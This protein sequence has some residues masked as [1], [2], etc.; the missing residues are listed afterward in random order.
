MTT[1]DTE[2]T[3]F[4]RFQKQKGLL[5]KLSSLSKAGFAQVTEQMSFLSIGFASATTQ[6]FSVQERLSPQDGRLGIKQLQEDYHRIDQETKAVL[7]GIETLVGQQFTIQERLQQMTVWAMDLEQDTLLP[8]MADQVKMQIGCELERQTLGTIVDGL[9]SQIRTLIR[10]V[11]LSTQESARLLQGSSRRLSA[12]LETSEHYFSTLKSRSTTLMQQMTDQVHTMSLGCEKL[13]GQTNQVS[14]ILFEMMQDIQVDD[15]TAQRLEHLIATMGRIEQ[16]LAVAKLKNTDKRWTVIATRIAM[17]QLDDLC[18]DL[19]AAVLSLHQHLTRIE[20]VAGERKETMVSAR[21]EAISF[22]KNIADLSYLLGALLRLSV[23]DDNFSIEILRNFS[24]TENTLFQTR[25]ALEMLVLTAHRLEK[26][27]ATL[28]CKNNHRVA[29]LTGIVNQLVARIQ[30]EGAV[31]SRQLLDV[32]AQLQDVGLS[33]SEQ[34][35]PRIMRVITLL[36]RVPLRAQQMEAD[37]G[38][39]LAL[40]SDIIS[41]TQAIIVQVEMLLA[42]MDFHENIKKGVEHSNRRIQELLPELVGATV[43]NALGGDVS[44]LAEEFADLASLYTMARERKTHGSVLGAESAADDGD[45]F[46]MF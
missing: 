8:T 19:V 42:D 6:A 29:T 27:L 22:E 2:P 40:F 17:E 7:Q 44:N 32:T 24:K 36:R 5:E 45:G 33:Y 28:E 18:K 46:E 10:E 26:L 43:L 34:S 41:E 13:E 1:P 37:H 4:V 38:D 23:F 35:T 25:R 39:V 11:I 21:D 15:I 3:P 9:M 20:G 16:R 30:Q 12:D 14:R 31:Q